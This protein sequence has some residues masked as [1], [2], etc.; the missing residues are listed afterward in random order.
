M[1]WD[2]GPMIANQGSVPVPR[3]WLL[4]SAIVP[5]RRII[6]LPLLLSDIVYANLAASLVILLPFIPSLA[7][8]SRPNAPAV[9]LFLSA[10]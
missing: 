6:D 2:R 3:V 7:Y 8:T 1:D 5:L 9:G 10:S 4:L